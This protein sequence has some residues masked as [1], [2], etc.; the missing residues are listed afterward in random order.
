MNETPRPHLVSAQ[1]L[2]RLSLW[3]RLT[4]SWFAAQ[5]LALTAPRAA[6]CF[7]EKYARD[8]RMLLVLRAVKAAGFRR[9]GVITAD[10]RRLTGR[11]VAGVKLRR[12]L[13][14]GTFSQRACAICDAL[15][16]PDRWIAYIVKRLQRGFT[17]LQR[18]PAVVRKKVRVARA[19]PR[20]GEAI[21][22]S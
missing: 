18:A 22:S 15:A 10:M 2:L 19:A 4:V 14:T 6:A 1:R 3:L 17:K 16:A 20:M 5:V 12:A 13:R 9:G 21:N 8:A 11:G 7:L